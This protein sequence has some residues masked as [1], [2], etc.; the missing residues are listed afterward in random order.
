MIPAT[1]VPW[2]S[3]SS[4]GAPGTNEVPGSTARP[5][6]AFPASTPESTTATVT[7]LPVARA[8]D[9]GTLRLLSAA[10]DSAT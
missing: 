7:P 2:P 10:D 6:W 3:R 5:R 9:C 1:P 8:Q 4:V